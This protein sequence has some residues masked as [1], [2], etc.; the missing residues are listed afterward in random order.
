MQDGYHVP[1]VKEVVCT[2]IA[3]RN[4]DYYSS[5]RIAREMQHCGGERE[6]LQ[7]VGEWTGVNDTKGLPFNFV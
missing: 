7:R 1:Y 4:T 6:R 5:D 3:L 2:G